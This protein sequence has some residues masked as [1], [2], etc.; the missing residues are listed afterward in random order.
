MKKYSTLQGLRSRVDPKTWPY[1]YESTL[2]G[3][4]LRL[5]SWPS[6]LLSSCET[7]RPASARCA[8]SNQKA[9]RSTEIPGFHWSE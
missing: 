3:T 8:E 7:I 1:W 5:P 9:Y 2:A 4:D 6:G